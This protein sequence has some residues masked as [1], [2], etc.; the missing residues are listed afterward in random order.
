MPDAYHLGYVPPKA[1]IKKT[2]FELKPLGGQE[3]E[4]LQEIMKQRH[5]RSKSLQQNS[6]GCNW[7]YPDR[8]ARDDLLMNIKISDDDYQDSLQWN[9]PYE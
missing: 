3:M 4:D 9:E 5:R 1:E 6:L 7:K 2:F 8:H